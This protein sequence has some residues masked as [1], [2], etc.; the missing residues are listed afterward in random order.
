MMCSLNSNKRRF[1]L[2]VKHFLDG[3]SLVSASL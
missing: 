2:H 1:N 3:W